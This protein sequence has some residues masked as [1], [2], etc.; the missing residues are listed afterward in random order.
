MSRA[1]AYARSGNPTE[2]QKQNF[3]IELV[4]TF[5][6]AESAWHAYREHLSEHGFLP[7]P[8]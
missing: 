4:L 6:D 1:F 3:A 2:E 7:S 5:N 8:E